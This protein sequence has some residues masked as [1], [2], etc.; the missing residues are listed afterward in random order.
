LGSIFRCLLRRGLTSRKFSIRYILGD[1]NGK[2]K[3]KNIPR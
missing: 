3:R 2:T 1:A